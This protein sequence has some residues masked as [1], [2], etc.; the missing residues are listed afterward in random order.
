[1]ADE[2]VKSAGK[3]PMGGSHARTASA[4][5]ANQHWWP[6]QL[7]LKV[8]QQRSPLADPH[9]RGLRLRRRSSR[10]STSHAAAEG[11]RRADDDLAGVVAGRL[12]ALRSA[13]HPDGVAQRG[14]VPH[15]RR[16]RRLGLRHAALRAAQQLAGQREPRQGAPAALADQAEVRP[17]DLVGRPDDPGRQ[18]RPGDDGL[19]DLRLR[20]RAR[21]RLGARGRLLGARGHVARRRA[22]HRRPGARESARRRADG[23]HL[24][25]PGGAERQRRI[26]WPRRATSARRS[27]AWP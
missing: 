17:E 7:N 2:N 22:L 24:R 21:G 5:T 1:M 25:E 11:P 9:G 23:P 20:R 14:H 27:R 26:R 16:A 6:E 8:L 18:P 10:A 15:R 13:L 4:S 12:R 19:Q 3:C